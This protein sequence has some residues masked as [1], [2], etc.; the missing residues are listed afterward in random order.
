MA[1][2]VEPS[3]DLLVPIGAATVLER[4]PGLDYQLRSDDRGRVSARCRHAQKLDRCTFNGAHIWAILYVAF[5]PSIIAQRSPT[6]APAARRRPF[7]FKD[8]SP[9]ADAGSHP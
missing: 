7:L 9:S 1:F 5:S 8:S 3:R 6:G 2:A 4:P